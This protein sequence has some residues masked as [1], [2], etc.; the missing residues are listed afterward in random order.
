MEEKT[1]ITKKQAQEMILEFN[2]EALWTHFVNSL[3]DFFFHEIDGVLTAHDVVRDDGTVYVE[4]GEEEWYD[5][6]REMFFDK[7]F[8]EIKETIDYWFK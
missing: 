8:K 6:I 4:Y 2:D 1:K 3:H 7:C 5:D